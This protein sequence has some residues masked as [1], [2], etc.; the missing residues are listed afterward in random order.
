MR[1]AG[2]LKMGAADSVPTVEAS[3]A[4]SISIDNLFFIFDEF[5]RL[6][7]FLTRTDIIYCFSIKKYFFNNTFLSLKVGVCWRGLLHTKL[8]S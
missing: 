5:K 6:M 1:T 7:C 8:I 2:A 3:N 4:T